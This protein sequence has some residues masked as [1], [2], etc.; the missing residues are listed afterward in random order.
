M[1]KPSRVHARVI[2][3]PSPKHNQDNCRDQGANDCG[4][5]A[6]LNA[7][8]GTDSSAYKQMGSHPCRH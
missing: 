2:L 3:M 6:S 1:R 4:L 8:D 7:D 5:L